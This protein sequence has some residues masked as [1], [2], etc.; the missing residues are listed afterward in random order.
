LLK[1][2]V[3]DTEIDYSLGRTGGYE[4]IKLLSGEFLSTEECT[5]DLHEA[6]ARIEY[7]NNRSWKAVYMVRKAT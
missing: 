1:E 5:D 3:L 2:K 4:I 7:L 6:S